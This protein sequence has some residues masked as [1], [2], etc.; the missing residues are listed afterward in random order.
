[1]AA[2][3]GSSAIQSKDLLLINDGDDAVLEEDVRP[4]EE[5]EEQEEVVIQFRPQVITTGDRSYH[6]SCSSRSSSEE[7]LSGN[8]LIP[9][10]E[11][12]GSS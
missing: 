9:H 12:A 5:Q 1:M 6:Y 2:S 8:K 10:V 11:T 3:A 7:S 4:T